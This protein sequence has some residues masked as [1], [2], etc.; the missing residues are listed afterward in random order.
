MSSISVIR[1]KNGGQQEIS[2]LEAIHNVALEVSKFKNSS[3]D[4]ADLTLYQFYCC[5]ECTYKSQKDFLFRDHMREN[6]ENV[7]PSKKIKLDASTLIHRFLQEDNNTEIHSIVSQYVIT[8]H[9]HIF[10]CSFFP[11]SGHCAKQYWC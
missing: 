4:L 11:F 2:S 3:W 6:H 10:Q 5:P 1:V 8:N 9:T 7:V